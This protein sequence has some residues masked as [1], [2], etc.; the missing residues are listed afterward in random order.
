M[1]VSL[2]GVSD[3]L[4][5]HFESFPNTC[6]KPGYCHFQ[7]VCHLTKAIFTSE[8]PNTC[9]RLLAYHCAP[10]AS[11]RDNESWDQLPPSS[12]WNTLF[13]KTDWA[14]RSRYGRES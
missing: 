6:F 4:C 3:G 12:L 8:I 5:C 11:I 2:T 14:D 7:L 10:L 9:I 1:K 13:Q